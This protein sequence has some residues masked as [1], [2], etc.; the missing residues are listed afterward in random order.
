M[1]RGCRCQLRR[2]GPVDQIEIEIIHTEPIDRRM[3]SFERF[4]V[5]RVLWPQ[6][7]RE[8]DVLPEHGTVTLETPLCV[9]HTALSQLS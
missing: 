9:R 7:R 1:L 4:L 3:E 6:L 8:K 5:A 2:A